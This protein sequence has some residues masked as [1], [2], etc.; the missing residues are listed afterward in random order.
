MFTWEGRKIVVTLRPYVTFEYA[1]ELAK[2]LSDTLA[3]DMALTAEELIDCIS[4]TDVRFK[5]LQGATF[6]TEFPSEGH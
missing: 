5:N 3:L 2:E 1:T 4:R 6:A